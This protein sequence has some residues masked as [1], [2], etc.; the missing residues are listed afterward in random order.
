MHQVAEH[1]AGVGK[2]PLLD[3]FEMTGSAPSV[4]LASAARVAAL[5]KTL[6]LSDGADIPH[7]PILL[8]DDT[9]RTGWTM[10]VAAALLR[11]GGAAAVLPLVVHQ[12][13]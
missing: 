9:Y 12:H 11:D 6:H 7:G 4:D 10:T 1:I 5:V 8:V 2:L 3:V 13:P